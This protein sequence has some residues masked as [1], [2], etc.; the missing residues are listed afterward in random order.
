[1]KNNATSNIKTCQVLSSTGLDDVIIYLRDGPFSSDIGI[2]N[3][4]KSIGSFWFVYMNE[5]HLDSY[6]CAPP[7]KLSK[8]NIK[9]NGR[10]LY[11]EYKKKVLQLKKILIVQP[12]VYI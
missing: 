4:H 6:G 11:S 8:F 10:F 7:N 12:T 9:R 3:P 1:M 2:V 5:I